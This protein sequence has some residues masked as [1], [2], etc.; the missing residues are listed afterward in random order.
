VTKSDDEAA[1]TISRKTLRRTVFA[2]FGFLLLFGV[3]VGGYFVGRQSDSSNGA[4]AATTTTTTTTSA[5]GVTEK[6]ATQKATYPAS[7][8]VTIPLPEVAPCVASQPSDAVR[9]SNV[10][11]GCATGNVNI[12]HIVWSSWGNAAA[13]GKGTLAVNSCQPYCAA[14]KF[15]MYP[16]SSI[17]VSDPVDTSGIPVFQDV[18]VDPN[19]SGALE[20]NSDPGGW[21]WVP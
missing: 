21:G 1:L 4:S 12:S 15:T 3:G 13:Y 19:G 20:S 10:F 6:R 9:P 16:G 17:S 11:I 14:G 18:T 5:T 2:L 7:T 8:G